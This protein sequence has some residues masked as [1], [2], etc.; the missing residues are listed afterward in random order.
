MSHPFRVTVRPSA[1]SFAVQP[2]ESVLD[3]ALRQ[4]V[5]LAHDCTFGG[6]GSCR[7]A[8][9]EGQVRYEDWPSALSENEAAAGFALMC[10]ARPCSDLVIDVEP[11]PP[12]AAEPM[13]TRA[14]VRSLAPYTVSVLHLQLELPELTQLEFAP[15]QHMNVHF[16]EGLQRSFSMASAPG[17]NRVDFHVR[18][19][20]GGWFTDGVL[21]RLRDGDTLEVEIPLGRFHCRT[22]DY[23]PLLMV[24]TGTG[25]SPIKSMLEALLDAADCPPVWLY[26]G[27][28]EEGDL[29]LDEVIRSWQ[30]RL[31][32]FQY[33]PVLSRAASAWQGRRGFV[34][35]AVLEDLA[36]LSEHSIY[37]CGSPAMIGDAKQA[38]V[39]H[40]AELRHV[41]SDGFSFQHA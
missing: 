6:C 4:G 32:D 23:R 36:D 38:F 11:R 18:R 9:L 15:G 8:L 31:Y 3:A 25:I 39:E 2:G 20:P 14:V 17:G 40:G 37:L 13:R 34:Q 1:E 33:V 29:Y 12:G 19:I 26:W 16:S 30:G 10:Q 27:M 5:P 7:V 21:P 22:Q 28:R 35:Q 24:A 41:H